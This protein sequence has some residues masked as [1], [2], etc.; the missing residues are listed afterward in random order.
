VLCLLWQLL[1]VINLCTQLGTLFAEGTTPSTSSAIQTVAVSILTSPYSTSTTS[2]TNSS[3]PEASAISGLLPN[4]NMAAIVGAAVGVPLR[5]AV[6]AGLVLYYRERRGRIKT[7][8]VIKSKF[9]ETDAARSQAAVIELQKLP[10]NVYT[11]RCEL[12]STRRHELGV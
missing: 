10:N 5:L 9:S 2:T 4:S 7:E 3:M 8:R 6:V 11:R 1:L 12:P